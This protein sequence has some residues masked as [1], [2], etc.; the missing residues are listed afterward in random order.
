[1]NIYPHESDGEVTLLKLGSKLHFSGS[2]FHI[3][4]KW[5]HTPRHNT[6]HVTK[7]NSVQHH[8]KLN[9]VVL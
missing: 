6:S 8:M 1:M 3:Q 4:I 2:K 7:Q 5:Y 9:D